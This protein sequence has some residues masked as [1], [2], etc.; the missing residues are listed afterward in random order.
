VL[1][2]YLKIFK[3]KKIYKIKIQEMQNVF[4]KLI[5]VYHY[6]MKCLYKLERG[7]S[8]VVGRVLAGYEESG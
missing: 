5:D 1:L 4:A 2:S 3:Y 8:S 6:K 7:G